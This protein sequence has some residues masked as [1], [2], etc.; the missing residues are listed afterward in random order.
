[1]INNSINS[2]EESFVSITRLSQQ[3]IQVLDKWYSRQNILI[4]LDIFTEQ[5]NQFFKYSKQ[6]ENKNLVSVIAFYMAIKHYHEQITLH[7]N[8]NKSMSLTSLEKTSDFAIKQFK[9]AKTKVKR[10]KLINLCSVIRKLKNEGCSFRDVSKILRSKYRFQVSHT[11]IS[12]VW[13][14]LENEC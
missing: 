3:A 4:K 14:E 5:R 9:K 1:M 2:L 8:K 7:M 10:E 12:Q 6:L 11:Y 13:K